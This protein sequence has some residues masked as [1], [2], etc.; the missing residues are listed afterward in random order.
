MIYDLRSSKRGY[1]M[2]GSFT[3]NKSYNVS[4]PYTELEECGINQKKIIC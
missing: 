1:L 3:H 4:E 2:N